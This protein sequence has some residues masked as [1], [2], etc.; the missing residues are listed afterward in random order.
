MSDRFDRM[1][2]FLKWHAL[3]SSHAADQADAKVHTANEFIQRIADSGWLARTAVLGQIILDHS[4]E[5]RP[6]GSDSGQLAQAVLL[7][8]GGFGILLW[9]SEDYVALREVPEGLEA[10]AWV[11]FHPFDEC[12][13]ALKALLL[14]QIDPLLAQLCKK[15]A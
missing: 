9:D 2:E 14:S 6:G 5:P 12:E 4:Y 11:M 1:V 3:W 15:L 8:P 13:P 10:E 7:V